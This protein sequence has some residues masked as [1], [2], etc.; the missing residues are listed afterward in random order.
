MMRF[1]GR[2]FSE[3]S[4]VM[5]VLKGCAARIPDSI[6]IVLP[7][8]PASSGDEGGWKPRIWTPRISSS[9]PV[10]RSRVI[11]SIGTPSARRQLSVEPQSAPVE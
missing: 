6:R 10:V 7:E 5:V 11:C 1:I 4:P 2:R 9:M 8:F 3:L